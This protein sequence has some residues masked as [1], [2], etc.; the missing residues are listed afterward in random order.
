MPDTH[1]MPLIAR[2][3]IA[4]A[5]GGL[6]VCLVGLIAFLTV[7]DLFATQAVLPMLAQSYGVGPSS[8]SLA[9][10]ASTL[11]MAVA[12]IAVGLFGDRIE[13][14]RG[15]LVS[16][17][18]L[19]IPTACLSVAPDLPSFAALRVAQGLLMATAFSL[20]L[21]Y[22]G[23][24]FTPER[25]GGAIAAY[26]TGNVASNL[27]GRLIALGAA[28]HLGLAG[29]FLVFSALNLAGAVVVAV[30]LHPT[31]GVRPGGV[32]PP[33]VTASAWAHLRHPGLRSAFGIG[34]C[35]LFAFI[36]T[37]TYVN[38]LLVQAPFSLA[39]MQ[40]GLVYFVFLPS[41]ATTPLA[42]MLVRR[43]GARSTLWLSLAVAGAALP[44][45]LL[46][47]LPWVLCG[48]ALVGLGTFWAQATATAFVARSALVDR[49]SASGIYLAAYFLGGLTGTIV[50][51][52]LFASHGWPACVGG[53]GVALAVAAVLA[54]WMRAS[55]SAA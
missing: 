33:S 36:G 5:N 31:M 12:G 4:R 15:I 13:P 6:V 38:F 28:D 44:M 1:L 10:N 22:L 9:V 40:L 8:M 24:E 46:G 17:A 48:L 3:F 11:G 45:L 25:A 35:I 52:W 14:R 26:I 54:S 49:A 39:M 55:H 29:N 27:F 37:F 32:R 34:F 30:V 23:Q 41:I 18:V 51:G 21:T 53:V 47:S 42:G 16:L 7:V 50:L 20:M 19:S 2:P 43:L